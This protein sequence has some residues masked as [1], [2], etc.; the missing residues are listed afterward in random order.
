M[1]CRLDCR[2]FHSARQQR[3]PDQ[4]TEA[5][6]KGGACEGLRRQAPAPGLNAT[7]APRIRCP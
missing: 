3:R 6:W 2:L 4:L 7:Q 5:D 1:E